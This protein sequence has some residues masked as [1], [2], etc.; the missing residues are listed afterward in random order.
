[1]QIEYKN[2][3]STFC[4]FK[5]IRNK[6]GIS[7]RKIANPYLMYVNQKPTTQLKLFLRHPETRNMIWKFITQITIFRNAFLVS[8][9]LKLT[10]STAGI[11]I[12]DL[13]ES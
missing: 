1:V 13:H 5:P 6:K 12:F 7:E 9:W 11:F 10:E 8:D 3:C 4:Q 2:A